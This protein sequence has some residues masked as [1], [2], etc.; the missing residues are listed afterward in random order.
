MKPWIRPSSMNGM[1]MNQSVAPTSFITSISRRRANIAVR[2]VFQISRM[3]ANSRVID[4]ITVYRPTKPLSL[5][6]TSS[7]SS[8]STMF[9]TLGSSRSVSRSWRSVSTSVASVGTTL[10]CVGM[11]VSLSSSSVAGSP[12]SSRWASASEHAVSQ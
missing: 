3:A 6:I 7:C 2:I 12:A 1:R 10:Y 5:E 8:A 9:D 11:F 4:R